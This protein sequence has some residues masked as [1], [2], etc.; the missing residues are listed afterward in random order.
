MSVAGASPTTMPRDLIRAPGH[1]R[2]R[3]LG[4]LALA[5][6]EALC[7]HGPGDIEGTPLHPDGG[8]PLD[9]ELAGFTVD[10][11]A[12]EQ[13]SGR[14]LYDSAF[15]SRPKGRDKSGHAGRLG[16]FEALGPCRF[17]GWAEGGEVYEDP[18]GLGF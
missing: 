6:M 8:I 14:R 3:S 9:D 18:F 17:A 12:L 15:L 11:Y 4:W 1:A 10:C 2:S 13:Q 16:L 5:W 7:V